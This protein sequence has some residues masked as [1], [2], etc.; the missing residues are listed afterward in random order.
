MI[1]SLLIS[2]ADIF[3]GST[4]RFEFPKPLIIYHLRQPSQ[5]CQID[6]DHQSCQIDHDHQSCQIDHDHQLCQIDQDC[7]FCQM[8][9]LLKGR[10]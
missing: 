7:Q 2:Q 3:Y 10:I 9:T 5:S 6:H 8:C 1:V 4:A